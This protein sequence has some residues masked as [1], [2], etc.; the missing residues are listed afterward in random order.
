[1]PNG[2]HRPKGNFELDQ[3][4]QG[5]QYQRAGT[6]LEAVV[7]TFFTPALF[8]RGDKNDDRRKMRRA[9]KSLQS[10]F[11]ST[12]RFRGQGAPVKEHRKELHGRGYAIG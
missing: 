6:M 1:M 9:R 8:V 4:R 3:S 2:H 10:P 11:S 7:L 5:S 12:Q